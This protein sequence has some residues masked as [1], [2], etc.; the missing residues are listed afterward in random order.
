MAIQGAGH[1]CG[2]QSLVRDG[3][4]LRNFAPDADEVIL[5]P[6]GLAEVSSRSSWAF[7]EQSLNRYGRSV[8]VLPD[9]LE[10]SVGGTLSVGGIGIDSIQ[11]G[12][13]IDAVRALQ[14]LS[15]DGQRRTCTPR[16]HR[17]LFQFAL[18]GLGQL[19]LIERVTL[20]TIPLRTSVRR[21][22]VE[23]ENV[24]DFLEFLRNITTDGGPPVQHYNAWLEPAAGADRFTSEFGDYVSDAPAG[25]SNDPH[26]VAK[27]D[28]PALQHRRERWLAHFPDCVRMWS[29]VLLDHTALRAVLPDI[30]E[31]CRRE[32]LNH[33]LKVI[34]VL[35]VRRPQDALFFP[36]APHSG[37]GLRFSIG[38]Y[39]MID[40]YDPVRI[41]STAMELDDLMRACLRYGGR[42]SRYGR[43]KFTEAELNSVYGTRYRG[44]LRTLRRLLR[45]E[46]LNTELF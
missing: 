21:R 33:S 29:D 12:Q 36:L 4:L 13:Q 24:V 44:K 7:V 26:T 40:R 1:S 34:Y 37:S 30:L 14:L 42:P 5:H 32:P 8:A 23:H 43:A 6:G 16:K 46:R 19:G 2:G 18:A 41:A 15:P 3:L 35:I 45:A 9:Y 25:R 38:L 31:R 22:V 28:P 11:H 10:L 20:Q 39:N 17:A 27:Y